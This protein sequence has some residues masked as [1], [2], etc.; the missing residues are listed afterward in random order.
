M[1]F[2]STDTIRTYFSLA[3]SDMYKKE[4]PQYGTLV[5]LVNEANDAARKADP[6]L[7]RRIRDNEE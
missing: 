3:M 7:D 6:E 4:V 1:K 5:E 2:V